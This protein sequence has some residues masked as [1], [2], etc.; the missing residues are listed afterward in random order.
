MPTPVES[1]EEIKVASSGMTADFNSSS[2]SEIQMVTKRGSNK[3]H[4]SF[5]EYYFA[6]N[7]GAAN[8]WDN[9]HTPHGNL[10]Y[11]PLPITHNSRFGLAI[12]TPVLPKMLGGKAYLFF[13]Y[14]GFR[15]QQSAVWDATV[16]TDL[17][18]AGVIQVDEG[19]TYGRVYGRLNGVAQV[20]FPLLGTGLGQAIACIGA[21]SSGQCLGQSSVTPEDAFRIG[22]DGLTAPLPA[23]S[24][25]L[26]Q[27]Y[28]PGFG[29]NAPAGSGA[30]LDPNF[31]PSKTDNFTVSIQREIS[32]RLIVEAGYIG[33]LI[34]NDFQGIDLERRRTATSLRSR[35]RLRKRRA[36]LTHMR[37][38]EASLD[39]C[40]AVR[41]ALCY[42]FCAREEADAVLAVLVKITKSRFLP[43]PMA[44]GAD[45]CRHR[46]ISADHSLR[47]SRGVTVF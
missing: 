21:T 12:G 32:S 3:F 45:W 38:I 15:F 46:K 18:R 20:V 44:V 19:G 31:R 23:V 25:T 24:Q 47:E 6:S 42:D 43:T 8:S 9:D 41:P 10:P 39:G 26:P 5:Y 28:I 27:P 22:V 40:F 14:E 11:T 13:N 4:G 1:I 34:R 35:Q 33:R 37:Q 30:V 16:P 2:G 36:V 29:G 7:L 17:M